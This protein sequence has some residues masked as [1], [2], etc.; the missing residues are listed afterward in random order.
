MRS[1]QSRLEISEASAACQS[2]DCDASHF[3]GRSVTRRRF[4]VFV[5]RFR[6]VWEPRKDFGHASHSD[7]ART[8]VDASDYLARWGAFARRCP[9][10]AQGSQE[11]SWDGPVDRLAVTWHSAREQP[12][13]LRN[14]LVADVCP[15]QQRLKCIDPRQ[16][17]AL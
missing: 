6:Q 1:L 14:A 9:R 13:G 10:A 17:A 4:V 5:G 11:L 16:C 8:V 7:C 15:V 12:E 2:V 3:D